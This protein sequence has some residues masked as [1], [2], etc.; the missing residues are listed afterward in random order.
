MSLRPLI[1]LLL[2]F[3]LASLGLWAIVTLAWGDRQLAFPGSLDELQYLAARLGT[4]QAEYP[5]SVMII[6][7]C[8]YL[9]KQTFAIP[10]SVFLNLLAGA[11]FGPWI[12]L[13]LCC[14]LTGAGSSCC[15]LLSQSFG[16]EL[17]LSRFSRQ[18]SALQAKVEESQLEGRLFFFLLFLRLFPASPNWLLNVASPLLGVP[19]HLHFLSVLIGL[20]PYNMVCVQTGCVLSRLVSL[21]ELLTPSTAASLLVAAVAALLP[22]ILLKQRHQVQAGPGNGSPSEGG[23]K[24]LKA[25]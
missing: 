17:V 13:P 11:L 2:V 4:F 25:G 6:F 18:L 5:G 23:Q 7:C 22:G 12:G 14:L 15:Y 3:L 19:L 20:L 9:Y 1:L 10:G 8:G 21:D 16:K 24:R